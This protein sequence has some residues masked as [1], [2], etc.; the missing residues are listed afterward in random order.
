MLLLKLRKRGN[1]YSTYNEYNTY[2]AALDYSDETL[3]VLSGT[4]GSISIVLFATVIGARVGII[5]A[6]FSLDGKHP[7]ATE[8]LNKNRNKRNLL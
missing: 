3:L 2:T 5:T 6:S 7:S 4:G 8:L 1:E